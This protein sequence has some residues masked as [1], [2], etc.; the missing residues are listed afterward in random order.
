MALLSSL[1]TLGMWF[2]MDG[3]SPDEEE[4]VGLRWLR[5]I[6]DPGLPITSIA[7]ISSSPWAQMMITEEAEPLRDERRL[8][9]VSSCNVGKVLPIPG[10]IGVVDES[11][12]MYAT[13]FCINVKLEEGVVGVGVARLREL[14]E[15][16]LENEKVLLAGEGGYRMGC[17]PPYVPSPTSSISS[18]VS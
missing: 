11:G 7:S 16:L 18:T 9:V 1:A 4:S 14:M 12:A 3:L 13:L 15:R 2:C 8:V 6:L 17:C 10:V 5:L